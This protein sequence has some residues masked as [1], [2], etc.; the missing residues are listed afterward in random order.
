MYFENVCALA[1]KCWWKVDENNLESFLKEIRFFIKEFIPD[2]GTFEHR[3]AEEFKRLN[4]H[5]EQGLMELYE[6]PP[7]EY[8]TT[9]EDQRNRIDRYQKGER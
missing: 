8:L 7:E 4:K 2:P 9:E 1:K 6:L 3:V 5:Y